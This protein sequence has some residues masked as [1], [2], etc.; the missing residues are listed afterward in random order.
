[1]YALPERCPFRGLFIPNLIIQ[2]SPLGV[3]RRP[4]HRS[5]GHAQLRSCLAPG[6]SHSSRLLDFK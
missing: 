1:M 5:P 4:V 6:I 2:Q 3:Q